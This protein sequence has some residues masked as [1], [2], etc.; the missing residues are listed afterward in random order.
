VK[1]F[2]RK[3]QKRKLE[4]LVQVGIPAMKIKTEARMNVT[5]P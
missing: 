4:E 5:S 2:Q 3:R 1:P